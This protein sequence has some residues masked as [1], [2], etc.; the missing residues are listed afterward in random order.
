LS[1]SSINP[2]YAGIG[3]HIQLQGRIP[4]A[5]CALILALLAVD[6]GRSAALPA[7]SPAR[8]AASNGSRSKMNRL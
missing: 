1:S 5:A 6:T 4:E 2:N 8:R 3:L 7:Q